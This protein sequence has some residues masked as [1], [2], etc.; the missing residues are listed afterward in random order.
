PADPA[1]NRGRSF[2][3]AHFTAGRL[4]TRRAQL[5]RSSEQ[6]C[7]TASCARLFGRPSQLFA[8]GPRRG[9]NDRVA[10][11]RAAAVLKQGQA[12]RDADWKDHPGDASA[13]SP[14]KMAR[15]RLRARI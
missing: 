12:D 8:A 15:A 1:L 4:E 11:G 9:E 5:R 10:T 3:D 13:A 7:I 2:C 6:A 14:A